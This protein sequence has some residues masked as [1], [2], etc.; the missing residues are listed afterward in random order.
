MT[1]LDRRLEALAEAVELADGRLG[2]EAV[3]EARAVVARAGKRLGLGVE[4]TVAVLAGPTG[5]GKS[6]LFNALVGAEVA[7]VSRRRPTTAVTTA[8]IWGAVDDALLEWLEVRRRHRADGDF[9]GLVLLDLPDFD[10]VELDH[11]LEVDRIVELA[12]LFVWVVDP[13]KYADAAWHERYLRPLAA[14][15][16]VMA[17]ALNQA[18]LL[19]PDALA[20][21][22]A[23][24][25]RLLEREGLSGVPV[26][27]VSARTGEG[28]E[29]LRR[30]LAERVA[31]RSAAV[32]RLAADVD[33]AATTLAVECGD[34]RRGRVGREARERLVAALAEAAGVP[35]VVRAVGQAHRRRGGLATGWPFLRWLRRLRPD[36]LRRLRLPERPQAAARTSL[37]GPTP[38]QRAQVDG[39]ARALATGAAEGMPDPWPGLLRSAATAA[40]DRVA[41]RL[42]RAVAGTD[43][44]VSSPRWW[45]L[46]GLLQVLLAL[47]VGAGAV[48]LLGLALLGYFQLADLVPVPEVRDLPLPTALV[49]GGVAAGLLLALVARIANRVG[50]RRRARAARRALRRQ[51]EEVATELVIR[52]VESELEVYERLSAALAVAAPRGVRAR[53]RIRREPRASVSA[54]APREERVG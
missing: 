12:D 51:V 27:A 52:P 9:D 46:V 22:R 17:V 42:D 53:F 10:S 5:A 43:L 23:D 26:L 39:A 38:L 45:R 2:P 48:W 28:L 31:A 30:L 36:P 40:E 33:V 8:A 19:T 49:L 6:S 25:G 21:C 35:T 24:L 18:D 4:T 29:A 16:D 15:A 32:E 20:A 13:Q 41:D 11:R 44:H 50:A 47:A 3:Q 54:R 34:G 1:D 14:H 7:R 37:P